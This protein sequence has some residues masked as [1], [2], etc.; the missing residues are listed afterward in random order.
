MAFLKFT[1]KNKNGCR[2]VRF[3]YAGGIPSLCKIPSEV[4]DVTID[5]LHGILFFRSAIFRRQTASL[6]LSRIEKVHILHG[7]ELRQFGN[8]ISPS[9]FQKNKKINS[10]IFVV[11]SYLSLQGIHQHIFFGSGR[12]IYWMEKICSGTFYNSFGLF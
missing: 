4:I 11:I 5:C 3:A 8:A 6:D 12:H 9:V 1:S 7:G 2:E 10:K